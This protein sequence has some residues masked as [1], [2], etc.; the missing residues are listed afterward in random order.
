MTDSRTATPRIRP[1]E[2]PYAPDV[3]QRLAKWMPPGSGMDPLVLFRTFA[4]HPE[5]DGRLRALG[6]G[7]LSKSSLPLRVRELVILR[8][9]ARCRSEY[10]WGVHVTAFSAAAGLDEAAVQATVLPPDALG[11]G[12]DHAVMRFVDELHD[13]GRVSEPTWGALA[14]RFDETQLLELVVLAGFYHLIAFVTN[15][16]E[17]PREPW[18]R[19]FPR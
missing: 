6:S 12:D 16:A 14:R 1:L 15:A 18:A 11:S 7:L 9:T 17:L 3:A 5:L 2:P 13:T 19:P 8:A 10:E 4:R